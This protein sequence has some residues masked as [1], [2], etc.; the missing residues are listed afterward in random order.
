M[1]RK[2]FPPWGKVEIGGGAKSIGEATSFRP[3]D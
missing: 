1:E 3:S 2:I